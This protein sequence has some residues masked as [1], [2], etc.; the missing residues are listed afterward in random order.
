MK[1][2]HPQPQQQHLRRMRDVKRLVGSR[3]SDSQVQEEIK[4]WPFKNLKETVEA[5]IGTKDSMINNDRQQRIVRARIPRTDTLLDE[6]TLG[7]IPPALAASIYN[8]S[9]RRK[10]QKQDDSRVESG[11][12]DRSKDEDF[13]S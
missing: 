7:G 2:P 10:A 4:S 11:T 9:A 6:F 12:K 13:D 1:E 8:V 3:F 5:Y